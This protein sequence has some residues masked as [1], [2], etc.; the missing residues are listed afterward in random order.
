MINRGPDTRRAT[1]RGD[2]PLLAPAS[3][4]GAQFIAPA[5][6]TGAG[7]CVA[8]V[9]HRDSAWYRVVGFP[10]GRRVLM[11]R[12]VDRPINGACGRDKLCPYV[13]A[14]NESLRGRDESRRDT[15]VQRT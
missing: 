3:C 1:L 9:R 6:P 10:H 7:L 8:V 11:Y 15:G 5:A 4:V 13:Y 12:E 14:G 2:V